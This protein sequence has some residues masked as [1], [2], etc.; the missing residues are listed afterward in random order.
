MNYMNK[1]KKKKKNGIRKFRY[2]LVCAE[3]A[4]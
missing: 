3:D 4:I 2:W 1:K